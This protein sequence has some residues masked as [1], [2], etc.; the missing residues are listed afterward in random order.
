MWLVTAQ[1]ARLLS[2]WWPVAWRAS[3]KV[4]FVRLQFRY[5][6]DWTLMGCGGTRVNLSE[7]WPQS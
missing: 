4:C 3:S 2:T 6:G 5:P 1:G 7:P